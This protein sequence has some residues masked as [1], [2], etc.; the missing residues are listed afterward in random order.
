MKEMF[1]SSRIDG[2]VLE[3]RWKLK[4]VGEVIIDRYL[5]SILILVLS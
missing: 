5:Q 3:S 1:D 2:F 4:S